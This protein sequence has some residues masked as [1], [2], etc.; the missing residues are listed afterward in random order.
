MD[1][2][3]CCLRRRP[4]NASSLCRTGETMLIL[5]HQLIQSTAYQMV[6][7]YS[8]KY[9]SVK[10]RG[11]KHLP[12]KSTVGARLTAPAIH[13]LTYRRDQSIDDEMYQS[14]PAM[15]RRAGVSPTPY[16]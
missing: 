11:S 9:A 10:D 12:T 15:G 4:I 6:K 1:S 14:K 5:L 8:P 13:R 2:T 3:S 16:A 7:L